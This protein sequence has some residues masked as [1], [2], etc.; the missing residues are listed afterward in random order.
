M[1]AACTMTKVEPVQGQEEVGPTVTLK[2]VG[3]V[4]ALTQDGFRR[5]AEE[6]LSERPECLVVEMG[7][8]SS[9]DSSGLGL[10]VHVHSV[11]RERGVALVLTN[12]P[13][14]AQAL[15]KRTGLDRVFEIRS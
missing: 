7:E 14:R 10:L 4:D 9:I 12:I 8:L 15:F 2:L 1:T 3:D 5:H 6:L 11:A 13:P